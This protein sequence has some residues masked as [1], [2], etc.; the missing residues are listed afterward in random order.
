MSL[1]RKHY[2]LHWSIFCRVVDNYGDIG[3]CWRLACMLALHHQKQVRLWLDEP[4]A[5]MK[6][7]GREDSALLPI[8]IEGVEILPWQPPFEAVSEDD[9][10]IEA[11]ACDLPEDA[12]SR[13]AARSV[14]PRW[15]NLEYLSAEEWIEGCHGMPSPHPRLPLV[16]Y[17][18]FPGFT[19][20]TGGVLREPD[21]IDI[22]DV[23]STTARAWL[24]RHT[25]C[26]IP[27]EALVISLFAYEQPNLTQLMDLWA[28]QSRP[29]W[30]LV[31]EG[32]VVPDVA[33]HFGL[34]TMAVDE[35]RNSGALN[36]LILPFTDQETYDR[37]LWAC[38]LN[39]VRGEDSFVR[40]QWAGK[41]FVWQIYPQEEDA[42]LDKL[43][44]FL[45]RYVGNLT[46]SDATQALTEFWRAWNGVDDLTAAWPALAASMPALAKHAD[47]WSDSL[48][49][50]EDLASQLVSFSETGV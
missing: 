39:F 25:G 36:V 19:P 37:L 3:V 12:L 17:F 47:C 18:F 5:L 10:V 7:L 29:I 32:R 24:N 23:F 45:L 8:T 21:L 33:S 49:E 2:S 38:D 9:V 43:E 26:D 48:A 50:Q 4:Q 41:P 6:I 30:L 31:P 44:I 34:N 1:S 16:R 14:P 27:M 11:F 15:I 13:M 46:N 20:A 35:H 40:A 22:R 42:H 28:A